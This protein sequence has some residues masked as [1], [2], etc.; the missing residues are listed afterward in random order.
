M[1]TRLL[2]SGDTLLIENGTDYR[3]LEDGDTT[4]VVGTVQFLFGRIRK[5]YEFGQITKGPT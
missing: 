3:L 2:E 1:S 4:V 5:R